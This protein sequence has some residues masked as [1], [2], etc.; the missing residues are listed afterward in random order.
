MRLNHESIAP[1]IDVIKAL[2]SLSTLDVSATGL[3]G[4]NIH[5]LMTQLREYNCLKSL[6]L[7]FNCAKMPG[8]F[9]ETNV[10]KA[11]ESIANF[12][13][14][15]DQLLHIDLGGMN[16]AFAETHHIF[17]RGLRKSRTLQS[18]HF[19]G[20]TGFGS[21]RYQELLSALLI[22]KSYQFA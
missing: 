4:S 6:N 15:S 7:S 1:L 16:F 20:I 22:N 17:T 9:K 2:P 5:L 18:C 21:E 3:S 8:I 10:G 14:Y 13:H 12:I 19:L 11:A